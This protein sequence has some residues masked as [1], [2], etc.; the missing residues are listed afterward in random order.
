MVVA[1]SLAPSGKGD[2]PGA[3][4]VQETG[5]ANPGPGHQE[6]AGAGGAS[7]ASR[8]S[9]EEPAARSSRK[10]GVGAGEGAE[11]PGGMRMPPRSG[12]IIL[13]STLIEGLW[14]KT[15]G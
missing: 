2:D 12:L 15:W 4:E 5:Q 10:E 14:V 6:Q 3:G 11:T 9:W 8:R 1:G 13:L 7:E